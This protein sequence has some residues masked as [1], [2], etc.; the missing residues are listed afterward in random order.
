MSIKYTGFADEVSFDIDVQI[1]VTLQAGWNSIEI[2]NIGIENVCSVEPEIWKDAFAKLQEAG[3][4]VSGFGSKLGNGSRPLSS[5]L[6]LDLDELKNAIPY[7]KE[8]GTN[9]IRIMS[10]PNMKPPLEEKEWKKE[11]FRRLRKMA[12]I[13]EDNGIILGHENCCG[14]A[15]DEPEKFIETMEAVNS[16][17]FKLI[18]DTG[19]TTSG[20]NGYEK[21]WKYYKECREHIVHIHIKSKK[22]NENG[23]WIKCYPDEDPIQKRILSDAIKNGYQGWI[24]IEPHLTPNKD[25]EFKSDEWHKSADIYVEYTQRLEKLINNLN[26]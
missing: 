2:R 8:C 17:A 13:A 3:I 10:Y 12:E 19:N 9:L 1:A 11:V 6:K 24:S 15:S 16:P 23:K 7:M 5:D 25:I 26:K 18:F 20:E 14:Y 21:T 4:I 22:M